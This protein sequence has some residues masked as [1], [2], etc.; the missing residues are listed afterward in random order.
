MFTAGVHVANYL[1]KK[2][3]VKLSKNVWELK[4]RS[5]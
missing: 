4:L 3:K 5:N 1:F 2:E